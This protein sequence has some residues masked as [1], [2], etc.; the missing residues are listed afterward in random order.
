MY[1]SRVFGEQGFVCAGG[2]IVK[3]SGFCGCFHGAFGRCSGVARF[4]SSS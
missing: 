1:V 2:N 3:L 4:G